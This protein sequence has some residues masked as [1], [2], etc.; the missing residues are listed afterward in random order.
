VNH[1]GW[2]LEINVDGQDGYRLWQER[3]EGL[4][5]DPDYHP[6]NRGI[7]PILKLT[8]R[9]RSSG[10]HN[11]PYQVAQDDQEPAL[12][13]KWQGKRALYLEALE[14]SLRTGV[15]ISDPPGI[16]PER[17]RLN[18]PYTGQAVGR[19]V[20]S[21]ATGRENILPLQI[22]NRG[23]IANFPENG[24][25]EVPA[26]V[27]GNIIEGLPVGELPEWLGGYTRLLSIQRRLIIEY[28]LD[29]QLAAL[30]RA[31]AVL[32]VF[33]P[34]QQLNEYAEALHGESMADRTEKRI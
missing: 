11:W 34:V 13:K 24:V 12:W 27:Q 16:H 29:P 7:L 6:G 19:L 21:L 5:Q 3:W 10:Y 20:E 1:D 9:L 4:E 33:A 31:L 17:S 28:L 23:A 30:K 32:P 22:L 2:V 8:E 25:V 15:P 26:R 14:E 18:Y